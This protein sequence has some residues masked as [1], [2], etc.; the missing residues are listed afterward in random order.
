MIA[1]Q[2]RECCRLLSRLLQYPAGAAGELAP[3]PEERL[4]WSKSLSDD[5]TAPLHSFAAQF[6]DPAPATMAGLRQAHVQTFEMNPDC[7]LSMAWL[8]KEHRADP[9][10][11]LAA[12]NE[13]Y[14]DA[15]FELEPGV[16]PDE[17]PV[18]LE[19][20]SVAPDWACD[21]L[22]NGFG[23]AMRQWCEAVIK[24]SPAY[25]PV[26]LALSATVD[27]MSLRSSTPQ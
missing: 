21:V 7:T 19:F 1:P 4:D 23:G 9:G 8:D 6:D 10:R 11:T 12:L 13:L 26:A 25:R 5:M 17:L 16:L 18:Q 2:E 27:R 22:L 15:G 14:H 20:L 3:A 24:H